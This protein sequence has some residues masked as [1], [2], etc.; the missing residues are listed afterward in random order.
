MKA[1]FSKIKQCLS[2]LGNK[3]TAVAISETW[4]EDGQDNLYNLE[5]YEIFF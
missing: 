3:F 4:L 1:N 2:E 5:G